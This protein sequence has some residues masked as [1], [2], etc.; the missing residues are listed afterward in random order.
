MAD[1]LFDQVIGGSS[2]EPSRRLPPEGPY[3]ARVRSVKR[4]EGS[5]GPGIRMEFTLIEPLHSLDMGDVVM[6]RVRPVSGALW[7]TDKSVDITRQNLM[8]I[9]KDVKGKTFTEAM[10]I[11]PSSEVV[12]D[13]V[14]KT[15]TEPDGSVKGPFPEIRGYNSVEWYTANKV[16]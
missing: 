12:L 16:A 13:I 11:L 6:S 8:R 14:H 5:K 4:I 9:N 2:D 1:N 7:V 10:E 15:T 3:L